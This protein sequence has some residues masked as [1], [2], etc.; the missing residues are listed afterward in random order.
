MS[1]DIFARKRVLRLRMQE[2]QARKS[3]EQAARDSIGLC[4]QLRPQAVWL[5]CRSVLSFLPLPGEP[6]IRPLLE[7]ALAQ[8]K[9]VLLPRFD[10]KKR[11]YDVCA[12]GA[13]ANLQLGHFGILEPGPECP[14]EELFG[15]DFCLVPGVAF[16]CKGRRLG[17]GKGYFDRLL[18]SVR[19]HKCGVV[20]D[21][22][23]VEEVPVEPHDVC[24]NSLLTPTRWF[25]CRL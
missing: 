2:L 9:T 23:L 4:A 5:E 11:E 22:Q 20:F 17:R 12:V 8:G 14:K 6:D 10:P 1:L 15:L 25:F 21:W 3:L 7:E 18:A 13:L 19:G 16:D 24:V